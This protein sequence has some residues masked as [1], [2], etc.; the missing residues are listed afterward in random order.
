MLAVCGPPASGKSYAALRLA[1]DLDLNP[2]GSHR[3]P[4]DASR[5]IFSIPEFVDFVRGVHGDL[6]P[7]SFIILDEAAI[8]LN[9]QKWYEPAAQAM[10]GITQSFRCRQLGA[11]FC[12]PGSFN[13]LNSQVRQ[14]VHMVLRMRSVNKSSKISWGDFKFLQTN[15]FT[16]KIYRKN[17]TAVGPNGNVELNQ[18]EFHLPPVELIRSYEARKA[19]FLKE[20]Y[21]ELA[22][23]LQEPSKGIKVNLTKL[24]E[25]VLESPAQYMVNKK[26]TSSLLGV[27]LNISLANSKRLCFAL[28]AD[29]KAG[30]IKP[31][32]IG[33]E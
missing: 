24:Y 7:G 1:W 19:A 30:R 11:I 8:S 15:V 13:F 21:D 26:F 25:K 27:K 23:K 22:A 31:N 12:F 14:L 5:V 17:P 6:P 16:G 4:L 33:T 29:L 9:A 20:Y 10:S 2:D 28:N 3:F 18:F 32:R